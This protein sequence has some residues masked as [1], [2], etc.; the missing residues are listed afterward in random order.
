MPSLLLNLS[1]KCI[2]WTS[3]THHMTMWL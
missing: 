3:S 2:I 1:H